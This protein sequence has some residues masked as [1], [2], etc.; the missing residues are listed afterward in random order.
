MNSLSQRP[1]I[2]V[3]TSGG[4]A[5]G[6]NAALRAIA[7]T[8][9]ARGVDVV[10]VRR[11]Y[12]GLMAGEFT[13]L[14]QVVGDF[15]EPIPS[16]RPAGAMGG[17]LLGS[18][19][20]KDF[21]T[22]NGRCRALQN[23]RDAGIG[24]LVVIGGNGSL[25]GA[26]AL[27][28]ESEIQVVGI[29]ASI[30]NDIGST[31]TSIGVDTALNTIL[32]SLDR[33]SDTARAHRRAFVVEVMGRQCGYLAMAASIA[34]GADLVLFPEGRT[35]D[36]DLV[37][38]L[39]DEIARVFGADPGPRRV[40]IV[41][42]EGVAMPTME[43]VTSLQDRLDVALPGV[44]ARGV[45]LGHVV[46]GGRPSYR[47]RMVAARLGYGAVDALLKGATDLMLAWRPHRIP[48]GATR[49]ADPSVT[50]VPLKVML[51]ETASLLDG[52]SPETQR[53]VAMMQAVEGVLAV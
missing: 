2:A 4:D 27:A 15:V 22:K 7:R 30:D 51:A 35:P 26:H 52:S 39:A 19:R 53:R 49:T 42:A 47:D 1:R 8:A 31:A 32:E 25:T 48:E 33:I 11:G 20:S 46:R 41:K 40:L 14:T 43:L 17:T 29:P 37:A 24:N 6:M 9:A 23:L 3:L 13:A 18:A 16:L 34:A 45:I 5:P 10:G 12:E 50:W 38:S 44:D 36:E 28:I 21:R